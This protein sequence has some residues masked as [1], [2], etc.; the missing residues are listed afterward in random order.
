MSKPFEDPN[1]GFAGFG[2][3]RVVVTGDEKRDPQNASKTVQP[4]A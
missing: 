1:H 4:N 3:E 2:E